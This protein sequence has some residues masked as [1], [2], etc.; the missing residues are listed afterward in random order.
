MSSLCS[1]F[2]WVCFVIVSGCCSCC[3]SLF[4]LMSRQGYRHARPHPAS[5]VS[6]EGKRNLALPSKEEIVSQ[7]DFFLTLKYHEV[8]V[9]LRQMPIPI[10]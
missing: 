7:V 10:W 4:S 3:P 8:R 2:W 9:S 1:N 5:A 6:F